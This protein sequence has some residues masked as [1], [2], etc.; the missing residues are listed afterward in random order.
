MKLIKMFAVLCFCLFVG[1]S[2]LAFEPRNVLC[3]APSDPG[4]GWDFT[5]RNMAP[6]L[7]ELNLVKGRIR[8]QN[9]PGA[10]GGVAYAHVVGQQKGNANL[11]VAASTATTT[12][13]A[14][15]QFKGFDAD[16]VRWVGALGAD[17]GVVAVAPNSR[18]QTLDDLVAALKADPAS[19]RFVGGSAIGGWDHLKML[20]LAD[21]AQVADLN[22]IRY[23]SFSSGGPAIIEI[24]GGRADVF[25]GDI[26]E[27]LNQL[28][29]GALKLLAVLGD[30]RLEGAFSK[31]PT[32]I[33]LGYN[34]IGANWRGFY[35]ANDIKADEYAYWT[36]AMKKMAA[37]EQ[38]K[39]VREQNGL[40]EF[41]RTGDEM[42]AF[43]R[44]QVESIKK[45]F[46]R[47]EKPK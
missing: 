7:S 6:I 26:S 20:M 35:L 12:R 1:Q 4:G 34:V 45:I 15:G 38:Y 23:T 14:L 9:M 37:S 17:Y 8:T 27:T 41:V 31:V 5:C 47:I 19:V 22:K 24:L 33:E 42:E 46:S 36:E 28:E 39:V 2:A 11:L 30:K 18:F 10:G 40:A 13:L 43:V 3:I 25:T 32:A 29:A 44:G 16:D 21:A